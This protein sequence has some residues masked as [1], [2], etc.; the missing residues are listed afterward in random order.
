MVQR[1]VACLTHRLINAGPL[2]VIAALSDA[3]TGKQQRNEAQTRKPDRAKHAS[4]SRPS[5]ESRFAPACGRPR[6]PRRASARRA[7]VGTEEWSCDRSNRGMAEICGEH[8]RSLLPGPHRQR[9]AD[10][11][12]GGKIQISAVER[13]SDCQFMRKTSSVANDA[14]A[15]P[16]RQGPAAAVAHSASPI[17]IPSTEIVSPVLQ[18]VCP[19]SAS[20]RLSIGTPM[21]R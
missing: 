5:R 6:L 12:R 3:A 15:L 14:T 16:D 19:G 4:C 8:A 17:S 10:D 13:M 18:T 7:L 11:G 20:T 1:R 21:G 2:S 9:L